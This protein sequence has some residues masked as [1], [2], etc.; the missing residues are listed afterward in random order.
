LNR[1]WEVKCWRLH[2]E[3]HPKNRTTKKKYWR[4]KVKGKE[5]LLA[6]ATQGKMVVQQ[7]IA[8]VN[9]ISIHKMDNML[10]LKENPIQI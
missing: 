5:E 6:L 9:S 3:H 8:A 2:L 7:P 10:M 4:T 1:H